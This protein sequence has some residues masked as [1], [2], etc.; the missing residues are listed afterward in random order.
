MYSVTQ[1]NKDHTCYLALIMCFI[2]YDITLCAMKNSYM[3]NIS[4]IHLYY[5]ILKLI[6]R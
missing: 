4:I 2:L 6:S 1:L 3:T 5:K